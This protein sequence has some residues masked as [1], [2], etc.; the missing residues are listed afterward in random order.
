MSSAGT[1][2]IQSGRV[3]VLGGNMAERGHCSAQCPR[4]AY[5]PQRLGRSLYAT[6]SVFEN[7]DFFARLFGQPTAERA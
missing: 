5:M 6:L 1:R 7:V 2:R 4:T 3:E